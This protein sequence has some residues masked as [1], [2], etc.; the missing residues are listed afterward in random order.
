[1]FRL[2]N[3]NIHSGICLTL[4]VWLLGSFGQY[5]KKLITYLMLSIHTGVF[6][7]EPKDKEKTEKKRLL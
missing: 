7:T 1:M 3:G 5:K 2:Q 6:N 4:V